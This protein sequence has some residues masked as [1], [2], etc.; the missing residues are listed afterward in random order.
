MP[1]SGVLDAEKKRYV[2]NAD[3]YVNRNFFQEQYRE[4]FA[5]GLFRLCEI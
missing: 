5:K 4:S 3:S 2:V 1:A